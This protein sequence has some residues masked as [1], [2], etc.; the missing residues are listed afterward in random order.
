[1]PFI[2]VSILSHRLTPETREQLIA[3]LTDAIV[4][5]FDEDVRDHTWVALRPVPAE[6]W[7]IA[8]KPAG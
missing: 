4:E 6:E 2:D 3:R 8:G 5:V 7:G 1:M